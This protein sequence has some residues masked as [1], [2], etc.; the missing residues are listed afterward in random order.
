MFLEISQSHMTKILREE[1]GISFA[2]ADEIAEKLKTTVC[3]MIE[4]GEAITEKKTD[5]KGLTYEQKLAVE[6][7]EKILK[8]ND[9]RS[10]ILV[11]SVLQSAKII[12]EAENPTV[13]KFVKS[14]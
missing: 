6:A 10:K 14:A 1:R 5:K 11:E 13:A 12:E 9:P 4:E 8:D 2:Q 7:F 3:K